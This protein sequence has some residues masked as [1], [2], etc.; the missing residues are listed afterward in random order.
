V[1]DDGESWGDAGALTAGY[2]RL[3]AA[4]LSGA[5]G[6]W[7][8]GHGILSARGVVGWMSAFGQLASLVPAPAA[9]TGAVERALASTAGSCDPPADRP[10]SLPHADQVVAVL[11]QMVLPLAA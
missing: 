1:A 4:V 9:G 6:G 8:L 2:E 10:V 11:A 5:A 7:R 3:R